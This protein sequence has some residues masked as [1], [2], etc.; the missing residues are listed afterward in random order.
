MLSTGMIR[1]NGTM[2]PES[3]NRVNQHPRPL[4]PIFREQLF[5][6]SAPACAQMKKA[7]RFRRAPRLSQLALDLLRLRVPLRNRIVEIRVVCEVARDRRIVT[8]YS[9]FHWLFPRPH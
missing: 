8:E 3:K 6:D 5:A 7:R 9:V 4:S 2:A 1:F